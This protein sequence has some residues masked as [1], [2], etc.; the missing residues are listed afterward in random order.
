MAEGMRRSAPDSTPQA[1]QTA[2]R[3]AL[4]TNPRVV[5]FAPRMARAAGLGAAG[6]AIATLIL[7][8]IFG[9]SAPAEPY[10]AV[11]VVL[12]GAALWALAREPRERR[13]SV[14]AVTAGVAFLTGAAGLTGFVAGGR[15]LDRATSEGV[16]GSTAGQVGVGCG[17]CLILLAAAHIALAAGSYRAVVASQA[18]ALA[19]SFTGLITFDNV[20]HS[21]AGPP[22]RIGTGWTPPVTALAITMLSLGTVLARSQTGLTQAMASDSVAGSLGRRI[23][24]AAV[25]VPFVLGWAPVL[26]DRWGISGRRFADVFLIAASVAIFGMVSFLATSAAARLEVASIEVARRAREGH[27]QLLAL[28]D[29]T[30]AVIYIRDRQGRYLLVNREYERLFHVERDKITGLTDHDLFPQEMA[31]HFLANDQ[32]ALAADAPILIDE[33]APQEDGPHTYVT[34]KFRLLD[35][36]GDPYAVC[37]ISTDI[38]DRKRAEEEVQLLNAELERRVWERTAELE[39]STHELDAFA[40]SVSHDLRAPLRSVD[41]FSQILLEDYAGRI[42]ENGRDYLSRMRVATQRMGRLID[43]L[44]K[45][46]RTTRSELRREQVDLSEMARTVTAELRGHEPDREVTVVIEDGMTAPGDRVLLDSVLQNLLS[47]AWK[48][49]SKTP[50]ARIEVQSGS[51]ADGQL[52]FQVRDNGAGFDMRYASKLF[53]AFERLHTSAEFEGTGIGLATVQRIVRR[54]GGDVRAEGEPGKGATF[55]FTLPGR[56]TAES[57]ARLEHSH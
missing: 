24:L 57:P 54:H 46:S 33:V 26:A 48:F 49:T 2:P 23:L 53:G 55:T 11:A 39:A 14:G 1:G 25:T 32:Q 10:T 8:P 13:R 15:E 16:I 31:D 43:D 44:L 37:G 5:T 36:A 27:A 34:V 50:N 21:Y 40:Y 28:I 38:T 4:P 41:G 56:L 47:N 29:N 51:R 19:A 17:L 52:T 9:I 6:A 12:L 35:A 7:R 42:D 45:L 30:S 22:D 3:P 20:L 18:L